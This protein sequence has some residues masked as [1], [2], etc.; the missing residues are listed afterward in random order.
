ML[1]NRPGVARAVLQTPLWLFQWVAESSISSQSSKHW[2]SQTI[3]AREL[4]FWKK[5][6]PH[7]LSYVTCHMSHVTCHM[8]YVTCTMSPCQYIFFSFFFGQ[9]CGAR[10]RSV[11]Y[12]WGR[13]VLVSLGLPSSRAE[14]INIV[15]PRV[16]L[17]TCI[18]PSTYVQL[19][20]HDFYHWPLHSDM[21]GNTLKSKYYPFEYINIWF[22]HFLF[23]K[24][25]DIYMTFSVSKHARLNTPELFSYLFP[26]DPYV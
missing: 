23:L 1:F 16:S 10:Q 19:L 26:L 5:V 24:Y 11:C 14:G 6:N 20:N 8:S 4:R 3:S 17:F 22:K 9:N 2:L 15:M 18:N 7:H 12:Q 13:L 21:Q 25:I